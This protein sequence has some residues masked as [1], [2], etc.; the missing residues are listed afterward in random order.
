M[1]KVIKFSSSLQPEG[2]PVEIKKLNTFPSFSKDLDDDQPTVSPVDKVEQEAETTLMNAKKEAEQILADAHREVQLK[3]EELE[4]KEAEIE[5]V[6]NKAQQQGAQDG[7]EKGYKQGLQQSEEEYRGKLDEATK[8]ISVAQ[9]HYHRKLTEAEPQMIELSVKIAS[10]IIGQ[11]LQMDDNWRVFVTEAL[12]QV[13]K[14]EDLKVFVPPIHYE[15]TAELA[16]HLSKVFNCEITVYPDSTAT[17]NSCIIETP[18]GRIDATIDSQLL[19][20]KN[21]LIELVGE[22]FEHQGDPRRNR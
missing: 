13:K 14:E 22:G 16:H 18:Y 9:S 7:F 8:V 11:A 19:E 5:Q 3:Y 1:S 21:K 20:L 10:K 17:E 12:N 15:T 2:K 4:R 6:V